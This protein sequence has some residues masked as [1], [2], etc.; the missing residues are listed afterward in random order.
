VVGFRKGF[1]KPIWDMKMS[2]IHSI[3]HTLKVVYMVR[4]FG[5][6]EIKCKDK[7]KE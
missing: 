7:S 4:M 2:W 3:F 6:K 1:A 5:L